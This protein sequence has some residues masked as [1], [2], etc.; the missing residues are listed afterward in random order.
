VQIRSFDYVVDTL[1]AGLVSEG[2]NQRLAWR[3][4]LLN[5]AESLLR[6]SA[7]NGE[8]TSSLKQ[9]SVTAKRF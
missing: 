3:E 9:S 1:E 6:L 4:R 8:A 7:E 2:W 5:A